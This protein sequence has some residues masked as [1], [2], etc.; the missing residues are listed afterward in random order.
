LIV[1]DNVLW[2]GS[3]LLPRSASQRALA[4]FNR[5]VRDDPRVERVMLPLRDG[6]TLI[7]K[8]P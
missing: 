6:V 5:A 2:S 7:R 1:A 8:R 3:V 4:E